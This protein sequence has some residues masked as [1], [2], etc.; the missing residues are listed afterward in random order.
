M[1]D[2]PQEGQKDIRGKNLQ[3]KT[4]NKV[5]MILRRKNN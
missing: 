5:E 2:M 3:D 4:E 1:E